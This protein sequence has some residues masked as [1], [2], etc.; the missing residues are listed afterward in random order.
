MASKSLGLKHRPPK[1]K[2]QEHRDDA[3]NDVVEHGGLLDAVTSP[4]DAPERHE[5]EHADGE[6]EEIENQSH[7]ASP[8]LRL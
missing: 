5:A 2:E 4:G 8:A 6:I 7:H 3:G 1:V